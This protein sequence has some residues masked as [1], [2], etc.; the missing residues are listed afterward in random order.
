MDGHLF[1]PR[2]A[3]RQ[4]KRCG[5][6]APSCTAEAPYPYGQQEEGQQEEG[7][8]GTGTEVG[9]V[10]GGS[11]QGLPWLLVG[12]SRAPCMAL[13]ANSWW[14]RTQSRWQGYTNTLHSCNP[15]HN[16]LAGASDCVKPP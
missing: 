15:N 12:S 9:A 13:C 2:A 4:G 16:L 8:E 5:P 7:Q 1:L 11:W 3:Q 6:G 14:W 10:L